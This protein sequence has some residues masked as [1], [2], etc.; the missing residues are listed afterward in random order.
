MTDKILIVDDEA[1]IRRLLLLTLED[2][3]DEGIEIL[4]AED[5]NKALELIK[6]ENPALVLLDVMMPGMNGFEVCDTI[7]NKLGMTGVIIILLTAKGQEVDRRRGEE[8]G[9]NQYI[10]KPFDPDDLLTQVASL[11][12]LDYD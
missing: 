3:E 11:L 10:T 12:G 4:V 6:E 2:L 9:A 1:P 7:K 5:G 8:V